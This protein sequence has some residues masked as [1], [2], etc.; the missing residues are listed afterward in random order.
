MKRAYT[1]PLLAGLTLLIASGSARA[2]ESTRQVWQDSDA[3]IVHNTW[4]NCVRSRWDVGTDPC[5]PV[6]AYQ[7]PP[8]APPRTV[9]AE[10]DR[11][12][13]F[14]FNVASLTPDSQQ[15]LNELAARINS[16]S[17]IQNAQVVGYADRIGTTSYN[18]QL[19]KKRADNVRDYLIGR[20]VIT[21]NETMTR[22]VGKTESNTQCAPNLSH[23][24]LIECLAPDRKVT[25]ELKYKQQ[26]ESAPQ[27]NMTPMPGQP[28]MGQPP[29]VPA[30]AAHAIPYEVPHNVSPQYPPYPMEKDGTVPAYPLEQSAA[31]PIVP[32][33]QAQPVQPSAAPAPGPSVQT[34]PLQQSSAGDT[35][36]AA[37]PEPQPDSASPAAQTFPPVAAQSSSVETYPATEQVAS[38]SLPPASPAQSSDDYRWRNLTTGE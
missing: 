8:P 29:L 37:P 9:I 16:A 28:L 22:W 13:Y 7:P 25:V 1:L 3:Q 10:A 27:T 35:L 38:E 6:V 4:G 5:A 32:V 17:D 20:N 21:D 34:Y 30:A 14:P 23:A 12:V 24:Q 19:S 15:R 36:S 26:I 2:D 33:Y 31:D 18:E 11:T